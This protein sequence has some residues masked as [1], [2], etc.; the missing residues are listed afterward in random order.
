MLENEKRNRE[1]QHKRDS[2]Y[3]SQLP[4]R[5]RQLVPADVAAVEVR[6]ERVGDHRGQQEV[7]AEEKQRFDAARN[8]FVGS[9][10]HKVDQQQRRPDEGRAPR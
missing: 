2:N 4:Q 9:R 5:P 7:C 10:Q 1:D 6:E 8:P 3:H